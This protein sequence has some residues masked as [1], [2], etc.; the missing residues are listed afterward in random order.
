MKVV[1]LSA[2][3]SRQNKQGARRTGR[4]THQRRTGG[5]EESHAV[6]TPRVMQ[7]NLTRPCSH[8]SHQ[9]TNTLMEESKTDCLRQ[10]PS[11]SHAALNTNVIQEECVNLMV[12]RVSAH[13][14]KVCVL[15]T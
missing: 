11:T 13:G 9:M 5:P 4:T 8:M 6:Q 2:L 1:R 15:Y 10:R 7:T 12:T 3:R 14:P